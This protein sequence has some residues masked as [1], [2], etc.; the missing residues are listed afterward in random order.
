[1]FRNRI[2]LHDLRPPNSELYLILLSL[3]LNGVKFLL[4]SQEDILTISDD[5]V[6]EVII[7]RL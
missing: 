6:G 7:S 2:H 1:M 3:I 4:E 5:L